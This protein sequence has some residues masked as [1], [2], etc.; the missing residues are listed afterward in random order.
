MTIVAGWF[1]FCGFCSV[2]CVI[3]F[4]GF[5]WYCCV[6]FCGLRFSVLVLLD[7]VVT[8][9]AYLACARV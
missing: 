3:V 4:C 2:I 5:A 7:L 6:Q 1:G 8:G 9:I